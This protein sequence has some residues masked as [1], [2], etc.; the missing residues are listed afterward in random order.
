MPVLAEQSEDF[1]LKQISQKV[2]VIMD[3]FHESDWTGSNLLAGGLP[4][5]KLPSRGR[6]PEWHLRVRQDGELFVRRYGHHPVQK[7]DQAGCTNKELLEILQS[8]QAI[9]P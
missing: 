9:A 6:E 8:L 1:L 7:L 2:D 5:I 3:R 4:L